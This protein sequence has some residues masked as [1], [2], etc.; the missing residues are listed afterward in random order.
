M[1]LKTRIV[2]SINIL[3][4]YLCFACQNKEQ[5]TSV[6]VRPDVE[7]EKIAVNQE[8]VRRENADI[9]L[10]AKRYQWELIRNES[11]LYY[12]ILNPTTG[13]YPQA[14]DKVKI[15]GI[16]FLPNGKEIYNSDSDGIKEFIVNQSEEPVGLHEL[17]KLMRAGEKANAIIPSHLGYGVSGDGM[18]VPAVS[19]LICKIELINVN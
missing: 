1:G 13:K 8:I 7:K 3:L 19:F 17:V 5:G 4:F 9:A 6:P 15:R 14:K 10:I 2:L 12:Q 11:G 16:I 18:E